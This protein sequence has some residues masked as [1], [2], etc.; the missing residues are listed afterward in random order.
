MNVLGGTISLI[1]REKAGILK[2]GTPAFCVPQL[3]DAQ[4][5]LQTTAAEVG[6]EEAVAVFLVSD[7]IHWS[8]GRAAAEV[9]VEATRCTA[10]QRSEAC[11]GLG[12]TRRCP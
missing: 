9:V 5:V 2:T 10:R 12:S 3:P 1:A 6:G 4:Q 7:W 11:D 8:P